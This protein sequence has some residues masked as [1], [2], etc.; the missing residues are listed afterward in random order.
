M[1]KTTFNASSAVIAFTDWLATH[2]RSLFIE[3]DIK[4]SRFVPG[5]IR[6]EVVGLDLLEHY[7]WRTRNNESGGWRETLDYLHDLGKTL[8][9]AIEDRNDDKVLDAC[10]SILAWGGDRNRQRGATLFLASLHA[11]GKLAQYLERSRRAFALDDA[12][13]DMNNPPAVKMNSM[14]TKV[15][16]LAS[17]DGLPIY[18]SRVAAAIAALV[19]LWRRSLGTDSAPLPV[20]LA[21][22]AIPSDR[23][24]QSLFADAPN[25]GVLSYALAL[26]HATAAAWCSAK[27]RLGWLMAGVLER[28]PDLFADQAAQDRMHAF[29]A[30]LF[31]VGYDINCLKGNAPGAGSGEQ[32]RLHIA[33]AVAARISQDHAG[34]PYTSI[35]TL[36]GTSPDIRYTGDIDS[37][38][39]GIWKDTP[40]AIDSVFLQELL[41]DFPQG[42]E[43]GLGASMTGKVKMDTLGYWLNQRYPARSRRLAS[44]LAP[45]LVAEGLAEQIPGVATKRLRFV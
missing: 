12:V 9:Q 2:C 25:P 37:G 23:T 30:S 18:D 16:A 13:I 38:F 1:N 3:L 34:L 4:S 10:R 6:T 19:E 5:G 36:T 41:D 11:Q 39:S 44:V 22:P 42:A 24:V 20:E 43:V 21:F 29:E 14:L 45:I 32:Q 17:R 33:R 7:R 31:M 26:T 27:I 40:F 28:V 15:H 8:Q 35:T